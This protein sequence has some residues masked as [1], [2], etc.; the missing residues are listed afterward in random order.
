MSS[1]NAH[2]NI[3]LKSGN[4]GFNHSF[5]EFPLNPDPYQICFKKGIP[6]AYTSIAETGMFSWLPLGTLPSSYLH[7]QVTPSST[8]TISHNMGSLYV[9]VFV[10]DS[11]NKIQLS[12]I[13]VQDSNTIIVSLGEDMTGI[14]VVFISESYNAN[15]LASSV[16]KIGQL[17]LS[18]G[19]NGTLLINGSPITL[20]QQLEPFEFIGA[21]S[22]PETVTLEST[23]TYVVSELNVNNK[24]INLPVAPQ[25]G[26]YVRLLFDGAAAINSLTLNVLVYTSLKNVSGV[27]QD[28]NVD[29]S[30]A[31][32]FLVYTNETIGWA[33]Y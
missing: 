20:N 2:G 24:Q 14:A 18:D 17:T 1:I 19:G 12:Q 27:Q 22:Y 6:F 4:L 16:L 5:N 31:S 13:H 29:V 8:W 11:D 33:V 26:D 15:V 3:I 25:S 7:E 9:G 10:Y 23:K 32:V 28:I 21:N 30:N